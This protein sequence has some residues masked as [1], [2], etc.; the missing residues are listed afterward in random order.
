VT[1]EVALCRTDDV[2]DAPNFPDLA[3]EYKAEAA[4]REM[5]WPQVSWQTYH[6]LEQAGVLHAWAA[7]DDGVL[8]G[9]VILITSMSPEYGVP[10][11]CTEAFFVAAASRHT[12]A[13]LRLL[14]AAE[15][16][17]RALGSPGLAINAPLG[18]RLAGLLP[19]CGFR[20][21]GR[22]FFKGFADA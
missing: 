16:K 21:V 6:S 10:L 13:G 4:I 18:G 9:F 19:K 7:R 22:C 11:T 3:E 5:P 17:A 20:E 12:G 14:A 1:L 15:A 8:I 2:R